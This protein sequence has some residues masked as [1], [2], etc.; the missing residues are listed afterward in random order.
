MVLL[1]QTNCP[2]DDF[3]LKPP[4]PALGDSVNL[5]IE[6][7][8]WLHTPSDLGYSQ[9]R[10]SLDG[11]CG[12]A[13]IRLNARGGPVLVELWLRDFDIALQVCGGERSNCMKRD[14]VGNL[15]G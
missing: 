7:D 1:R 12:A 9:G 8:N 4:T 3:R 10:H 5:Q 14:V 15:M 11:H 6:E 13:A 2:G